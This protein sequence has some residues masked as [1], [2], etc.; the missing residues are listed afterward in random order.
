ML[1]HSPDLFPR[2][3]RMRPVQLQSD[4]T[5]FGRL[6]NSYMPGRTADTH[7]WQFQTGHR[8]PANVS[9]SW[10]CRPSRKPYELM[11]ECSGETREWIL[12][13]PRYQPAV[14]L[15]RDELGSAPGVRSRCG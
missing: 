6:P 8:S 11:L 2:P 5:A 4:S 15:R 9:L 12:L 1:Q 13:V 3:W 10:L 14:R 7:G